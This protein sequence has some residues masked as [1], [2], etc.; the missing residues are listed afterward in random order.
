MVPAFENCAG[1]ICTDFEAK[2]KNKFAEIS[3]G[4]VFWHGEVLNERQTQNL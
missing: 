1:N 2:S 4:S 3:S